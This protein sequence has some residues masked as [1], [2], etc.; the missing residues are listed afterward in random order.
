[1]AVVLD[2]AVPEVTPRHVREQL[3]RLRQGGLDCVLATV[4]SLEPPAEAV[5]RLG[6]WW[7]VHNDAD[8][9]VRVCTSV[10]EIRDAVAADELAVVMHFQGAEPLGS[11]LDMLDAYAKLGLRVMQVSYNAAGPLADG[12]L[13]ERDAGLTDL[14]RNAVRRMESLGIAVDLSHAGDRACRDV[15]SIASRPV[16]ATHANAKAVCDSPRNLHDDV[17]DAIG[18][19]GGIVGVVA[20]PTFVASS[21]PTLDKL[22][23]HVVHIAG[24]I[25]VERVGLGLDFAD[26]D[27]A[28]FE[29][30]GYDERYYPRPPWVWPAGIAWWEDTADIPAALNARGFSD[31]EVAGVMG[32]NFLR[33]LRDIW[34][35]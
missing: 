33:V 15:L 11:R 3:P 26:E 23:D 1:M 16:I 24:R 34:G 32:E 29:Y 20:F 30:Y 27:E 8:T 12:C 13:S 5:G 6:A 35:A 9:P 10:A 17:I 2:A 28:D 14:G 18:A 4:A 19:S 7:E 25:G 21:E 22:V 31:A